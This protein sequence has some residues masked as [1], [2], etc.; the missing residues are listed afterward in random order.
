MSPDV[1]CNGSNYFFEG[2]HIPAPKSWNWFHCRNTQK[3]IHLDSRCDLHP[4]PECVYEKDGIMVAEDEEGCFDEYQRKGLVSKSA[5]TICPSPD[6]N[7]MSPT[8]TSTT[9]E[10]FQ[11][12]FNVTL[13]PSGTT[14]QIL[15]VR[16]DGFLT[17]WD[18]YDE[19]FCGFN[20]FYTAAIGKQFK[21][22]ES[23]KALL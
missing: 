20:A 1:P 7:K 9:C 6:H 22:L 8:V 14:V 4:N 11:C 5:K 17:C 21:N 19:I 13:I 2:R 15:G 10:R 12:Y 23:M 16:C 18:G 3:C